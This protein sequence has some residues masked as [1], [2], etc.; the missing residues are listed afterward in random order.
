MVDISI[1][2]SHHSE[3]PNH[4]FLSTLENISNNILT[5]FH[6]SDRTYSVLLCNNTFI[7]E[8]NKYYRHKDYATDVL[9]FAFDEGEDWINSQ[10]LGEIIIST[11]KAVEQAKE[12]HVSY[13]EELARLMIHG[14]LHL[15]GFD[16]EQNQQ[17][18][19]EMFIIQDKYMNQFMQL[20][21]SQDSALI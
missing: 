8:L 17:A 14:L 19:Q 15:I 21:I 6:Y 11:E 13:E 5:Q 20:Y 9:S 7:Q 4:K 10:S 18:H 12:F 16:H 1:E 2:E 3:L